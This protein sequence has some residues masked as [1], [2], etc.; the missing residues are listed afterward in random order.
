MRAE[1]SAFNCSQLGQWLQMMSITAARLR[2]CSWRRVLVKLSDWPEHGLNHRGEFR[3]LFTPVFL[4]MGSPTW[5]GATSLERWRKPQSR[6]PGHGGSYLRPQVQRSVHRSSPSLMSRN[7]M[8]SL[9]PKCVMRLKTRNSGKGRMRN[10]EEED[11][12]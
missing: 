9:K 1:V 6:E 4:G 8:S 3:V 5:G 7:K 2:G 11:T 10:V 12:V